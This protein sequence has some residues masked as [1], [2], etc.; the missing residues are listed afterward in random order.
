MS[1]CLIRGGVVVDD[2]GARRTDVLIDGGHIARV[3]DE[4]EESANLTVDASGAYVIPG[5]IDVHTHFAL[6]V[7]AVRSADDF[8]TGTRAAACGGTTTIIDFAGAGR[9]PWSEALS[10][11]HERAMGH[12]LIDYGF[13]LTVTELPDDELAAIERFRAFLTH[14]VASVKLYLAYP[15]R[16]MVDEGTLRRAFAASRATGVRVCVHA[17]DGAVIESLIARSLAEG[18]SGV[19]EIPAVR[20]PSVEAAAV[21]RATELA[22]SEGAWVYVVHLSSAEGLAAVE[23]AR[24]SGVDVHAETCPHY[25]YLD[26][27]HLLAG[28]QDFVC[29]PPLRT[30]ADEDALWSGVGVGTIE[31]IATDHCPFTRRDRR[32]GTKGEGWRDFTEV[33][34]GLPG[35]E[36]RL[37]L[38]YQGVRRGSL[39]LASWVERA[40]GA[41]ARM[42]GLDHRKGA[43]REG[44][45]ADLVVFDPDATRR[46]DAAHLHSATDHSP[47]EDLSI[48][49]WPALT[50]SRG[51]IV[52]RDGEPAGAEPGRGHFLAR[53]PLTRANPSEFR[54]P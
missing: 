46:L 12:A 6:P 41:P 47:Y 22:A 39:S 53:R 51:E 48:A 43:I 18:R 29:A 37:S 13:H 35:V 4:L 19:E 32:L 25:L 20:P 5:G 2:G 33:P 26:E 3:G 42:F 54:A 11:W 36:T 24:D 10:T 23:V 9:E 40:C 34:G 1:T 38:L 21:R 8:E 49:G 15:D 31:V 7:G 28:E 16:L 30:S 50:F 17:E 14:G 27:S 45:D 44:F 52:S